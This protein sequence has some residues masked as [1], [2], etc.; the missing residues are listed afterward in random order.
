MTAALA[1]SRTG[2]TCVRAPVGACL[3]FTEE[4][5]DA[6]LFLHASAYSGYLTAH[7]EE[8]RTDKEP[9]QQAISMR[10][11]PRIAAGEIAPIPS[12]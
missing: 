8:I 3:R 6:A 12:P 7:A 5:A 4:H 2:P 10:R 11:G 1:Q 9:F